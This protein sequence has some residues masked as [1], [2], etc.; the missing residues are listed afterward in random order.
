M[1]K[2]G[3]RNEKSQGSGSAGMGILGEARRS[4]RGL[5]SMGRFRWA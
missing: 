3:G 5:Y 2:S 1:A 4:T